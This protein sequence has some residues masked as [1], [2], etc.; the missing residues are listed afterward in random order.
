MPLKV[1]SVMT[2][3][4][5]LKILSLIWLV[6]ILVNL[7]FIFLAEYKLVLFYDNNKED[8]KC[9]AKPGN[10]WTTAYSISITFI[11]YVLIGVVLLAMYNKI[12]G[13]LK[14]S[15]KAFLSPSG[16]QDPS[17]TTASPASPTSPPIAQQP[18][19]HKDLNESLNQSNLLEVK[20]SYFKSSDP[21]L[22]SFENKAQ[23]ETL[24]NIN[25]DIDKYIKPRKQLIVMLMWIIV[26]FYV[27]L[28]PLKIWHLILFFFGH[29]PAFLRVI[30]LRQYWYISITCRILFYANSSVNPIL[31]NCLSKKFRDSFKRLYIFRVCFGKEIEEAERAR[32]AKNSSIYSTKMNSTSRQLSVTNKRV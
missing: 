32:R 17:P 25:Y 4:R 31:Y 8:Y 26:I 9:S 28:F 11:V 21:S 19:K 29:R 20:S 23:N 22:V 7:P 15:T 2:Q 6:S 3:S 13:N 18:N 12:T 5:T 24:L 10:Q 1:K 16:K 14:K 27:C 30:Q